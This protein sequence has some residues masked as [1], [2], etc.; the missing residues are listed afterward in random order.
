MTAPAPTSTNSRQRTT[1][2]RTSAAIASIANSTG[3]APGEVRDY[4]TECVAVANRAIAAGADVDLVGD[5]IDRVPEPS[6]RANS[7]STTT[8]LPNAR[9]HN[10]V[11]RPWLSTTSPW[12]HRSGPTAG[13]GLFL[14]Q[15]RGPLQRVQAGG[16]I[17]TV[18]A[19][20]A[21]ASAPV[22]KQVPISTLVD[23]IRASVAQ[24]V[25]D[26]R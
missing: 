9:A 7:M 22:P 20:A 18:S 2:A 6:A 13:H 1:N 5:F 14:R 3:L 26:R 15:G 17:E 10:V 12:A 4:L 8:Q 11:G 21:P 25:L 24:V 19:Q 16:R 23:I